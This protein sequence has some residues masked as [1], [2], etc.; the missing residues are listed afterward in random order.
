MLVEFNA[1]QIY[2]EI[3]EVAARLPANV[4]LRQFAATLS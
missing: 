3:T 2:A 4:A 1:W